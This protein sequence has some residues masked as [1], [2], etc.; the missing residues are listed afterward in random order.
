MAGSR[1]RSV[2]EH[3]CLMAVCAFLLWDIPY[4]TEA[5]WTF[6]VRSCFPAV[7]GVLA[8]AV[9]ALSRFRL[10]A[11]WFLGGL[12]AWITAACAYRGVLDAHAG[13]LAHAVL[14][15]LVVQPL[16]KAVSPGRLKKYMKLLVAVWTGFLTAQAAVGL[17]AALTG[18]AVF[19]L[20]GTWYIGV[21]LGDHRL[22]LN[23]YVTTGAVKMGLSVLLAVFGAC[24]TQKRAGR[25]AY[26]MCA[27]VQL[28]CL[29][30]T[31]CRTAF[32]AV[33]AG[34]G[35]FAF[36]ALS[37][38]VPGRAWRRAAAGLLAVMALT[39]GTYLTLTG[40]LGAMAPHVPQELDNLTMP[41]LP[42]HLLPEAAAEAEMTVQHRKLDAGN[43]FND[44]QVIWSA[45]LRLL[46][47]EP[48][49]LF[50]GTTTAI[51]PMLTNLY[52]RSAEYAG[53]PFAH[54]H[55]I[56]L[57]TLVSWGLPGLLLLA[58][59]LLAFLR[60]AWRVMTRHALPMWQRAL[61]VPAL[62]VMLCETVDCFTRLSENSPLLLFG[63][64]FAGLTL[65]AD[66][67]ARRAAAAEIPARSGVDVII[68]VYNASAYVTRAVQSA[69]SCP[70][71]R[72]ILVDDGSTD[73]SG[74][75]CD[76][77]AAKEPRVTVLHQANRGASAARNAGMAAAT[78]EYVAFLD[79]D[80]VLLPG[81]LALL[82]DKAADAAYGQVTRRDVCPD[83]RAPRRVQEA[84][85]ALLTALN[86]P[87]AHLH[88]H[89]WL[90]RRTL[91]TER[92]DESLSLG[93]DGEWLLRTLPGMGRI[94]R[95]CAPVYRYFVHAESA[96][97]GGSDVCRRYM[98][99]LQAAAPALKRV[100]APQ[101][102]AMYRLTHLLLML[103]HGDMNTALLLREQPPFDEAFRAAQLHGLSPR[104]ITLRLLKRR[105]YRL[106][107]LA[108]KGRRLMNRCA[109]IQTEKRIP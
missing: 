17:W 102:A 13:A 103:T 53:R 72:V 93:E 42:A 100:Q 61:P 88:T 60:A 20:K 21:N 24:M 67:R 66:E 81:A 51:A 80:D 55:S 50:T 84:R 39:A 40:V 82:T 54:V 14:A 106:A 31:D 35:G 57:Q 36:A 99:T 49:Y 68:P 87:T 105:S 9:L 22:Y 23:A 79:A 6:G 1:L 2:C 65:A 59:F 48:K 47:D 28:L 97:H 89:G 92:F 90:F 26:L 73:G 41:E 16:P 11:G 7:W 78:A 98:Q 76:A 15:F 27:A 71:A 18:H 8:A 30:L 38:R 44:R 4:M 32:I 12:A 64:L 52:V 85:E 25:A 69:L 91:L 29:S 46:R 43:L 95:V 34:L 45:A 70:Q 107:R 10:G 77:L 104:M 56:Y 101:A 83:R 5:Q 19:S 33:G 109:C 62:Y 58:G 74:G 108:V 75:I 94:H 63:C 96:I 37:H 3:I 86:D